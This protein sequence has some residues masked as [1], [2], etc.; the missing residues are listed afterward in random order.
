MFNFSPVKDPRERIQN[1]VNKLKALNSLNDDMHSK[2]FLEKKIPDN[3]TETKE[4]S[5]ARSLLK[6]VNTTTA[7]EAD[8]TEAFCRDIESF[9]E[10]F[11][12]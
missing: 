4:E 2:S 5:L 12:V 3:R 8:L 1:S 11:Q 10:A 7:S 6:Y 9:N